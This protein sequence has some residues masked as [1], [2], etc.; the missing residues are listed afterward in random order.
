MRFAVTILGHIVLIIASENE[1]FDDHRINS[2]ATE[3]LKHKIAIF[4]E[5]WSPKNLNENNS[6]FKIWY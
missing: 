3:R 2:D 5:K 6:I 4:K 1:C